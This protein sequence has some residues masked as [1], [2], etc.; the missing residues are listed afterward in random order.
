MSI[1]VSILLSCLNEMRH[2]YLPKILLNLEQQLGEKEIIAVVSPSDDHTLTFLEQQP[3]VRVITTELSNRAQRFDLGLNASVGEIILLHHSATLLPQNLA[4]QQIIQ[5]LDRNSGHSGKVWGGF[6]H[7]FDDQHWLLDFTSWYSNQVRGKQKGILY[8]DHCIFG[9]REA[10]IK[11]GGIGDRHIFADTFLS[12]K[13]REL[14]YPLFCDGMVVTSARRFRQR[15]IYGQALLNQV[16]KLFY[17]LGVDDRKLNRIYEQ[18]TQ[19]NVAY[20]NKTKE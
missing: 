15:G 5:T 19:I 18:K 11:V 17:H 4:L 3:T 7:S 6:H 10:L 16:L 12:E 14:S 13:L 8:F 20:Q 9:W 1:K 2:G